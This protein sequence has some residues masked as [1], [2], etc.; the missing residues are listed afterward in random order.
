MMYDG[1]VRS[2]M[3]AYW[4]GKVPGGVVSDHISA[5]WDMLPTL[6]DMTGVPIKGKTDGISM[7]P[8]LLG[9]ANN[10][11]KHKYLYW[12]LY[13]SNKPNCAIRF[14]KWKGI[15]NDRR[16]GL[17]IEL[18]DIKADTGEEKNVAS[19]FP[20]VVAE[21]RKMMQEAHVKSPFWDKD[22]QPL[23]NTEAACEVNGVKP[24]H[25]K[26]SRPQKKKKK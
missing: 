8:V 21:I 24:A 13:E 3:F 1:G 19:D 26:W 6:S 25:N 18:Y 9:D 10:Q 5:F 23:F 4:P 17:N 22:N 16:K 7:L 11:Q 2:P 14:G 12:E 15:V 20:E